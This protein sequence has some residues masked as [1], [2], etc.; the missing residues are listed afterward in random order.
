M[1]RGHQVAARRAER[2]LSSS[3]SIVAL[4]L[5]PG[6][7]V[8]LESHRIASHRIVPYHIALR[9]PVLSQ[10]AETARLSNVM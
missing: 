2:L 1:R 10:K 6:A 4:H 9:C 7:H 8:R 3:H 5:A